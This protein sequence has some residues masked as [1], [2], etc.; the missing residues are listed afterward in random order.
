M[1]SKKYLP[2]E[3]YKNTN[4]IIIREEKEKKLDI[5]F[6]TCQTCGCEVKYNCVPND[7]GVT[8]CDNCLLSFYT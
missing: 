1:K 6:N 5:Y 3:N 8:F 4:E 2:G 7:L